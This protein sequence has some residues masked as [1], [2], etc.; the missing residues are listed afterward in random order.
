MGSSE[1]KVCAQIDD[2][3]WKEWLGGDFH[4]GHVQTHV[5]GLFLVTLFME[6][7]LPRTAEWR[8]EQLF[9]L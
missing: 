2:F 5:M 6:G 7:S 3:V 9:C 8:N 4:S 1:V